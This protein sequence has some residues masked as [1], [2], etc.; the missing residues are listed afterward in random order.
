MTELTQEE[1]DAA[2]ERGI[3]SEAT[4]PHAKSAHYD[5][6][7]GRIVIE[8]TN[9]CMFAFPARRAQGLENATDEQ[10]AQVE[11]LG[12][13]YGLHWEDLNE[14]HAVPALVAGVFGTRKYMAHLAG[15]AISERK[16][17][18]ARENG[19][20]GGRPR[21]VAAAATKPAPSV[22]ASRG[23]SARGKA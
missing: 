13:G 21:K 20:R 19:K 9:G 6:K 15:K 16:A 2:V 11:V 18:A 4:E 5:L 7:T 8:L 10:I 12:R 23:P 22:K 1:Y 14:D 3:I 17:A